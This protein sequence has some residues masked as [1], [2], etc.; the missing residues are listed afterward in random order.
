M[1]LGTKPL[2]QRSNVLTSAGGIDEPAG[3]SRAAKR[4]ARAISRARDE[5][6]SDSETENPQGQG[7]PPELKKR[8]RR[9]RGEQDVEVAKASMGPNVEVMSEFTS[10]Y[11]QQSKHARQ[12]SLRLAE[13]ARV[14][15]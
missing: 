4:K 2:Y 6:I 14:D 10:E 3:S 9:A 1:V 12:D 15:S 5:T 13:Q 7:A 11:I 8:A